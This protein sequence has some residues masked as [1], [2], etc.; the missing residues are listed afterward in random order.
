MPIGVPSRQC[1]KAVVL[2]RGLG[3]RMRHG[4]ESARLTHPQAAAAQQGFKALMPLDRPFIDYLLGALAQAGYRRVCLVVAPE[5]EAIREHIARLQPRRIS[6][7]LAVQDEPRGTADAVA[8]ARSFAGDDE[9]LC[10]NGDN[11]YPV[12]VL[13]RLRELDGPGLAAY[14]REGLLR[15]NIPPER[16]SKFAVLELSDRNALRRIIEKP[17]DEQIRRLGEPLLVSM[18]CWRL[19]PRIFDACRQVAPSPRGELELPDA[20][21]RAIDAGEVFRAVVVEE[22]VLDLS[23]RSDVAELTRRLAGTPVEL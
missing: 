16:I 4:D 2:A 19:G 11:H 14:T 13:R 18:N 21:Q 17:S 10:V 22:P 15:G 20:V 6:V 1:A 5:H 12:A 9:F 23:S 3:T 7:D 8:A